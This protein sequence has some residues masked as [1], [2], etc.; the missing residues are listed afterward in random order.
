MRLR[1]KTRRE[2][3]QPLARSA[4]ASSI[5][6]WKLG[7]GSRGALPPPHP[8]ATGTTLPSPHRSG[9]KNTRELHPKRQPITEEKHNVIASSPGSAVWAS[10]YKVLLISQRALLRCARE[11]QS[12]MLSLLTAA[13][14]HSPAMIHRHWLILSG[15][16]WTQQ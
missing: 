12:W 10:F 2:R 11:Q 5:F 14:Q 16:T 1:D 7:L 6:P 15:T 4:L 13:S 3:V 8:L 9:I